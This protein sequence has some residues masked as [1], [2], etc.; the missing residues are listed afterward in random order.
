M[1]VCIGKRRN[2][3]TG[4]WNTVLLIK[5]ILE[6]HFSYFSGDNFPEISHATH[7][8]SCFLT[9]LMNRGA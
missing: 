3:L 8:H 4:T 6:L 2:S 5:L 1:D 9:M 7:S